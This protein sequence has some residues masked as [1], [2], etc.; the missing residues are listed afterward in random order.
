MN[1]LWPTVDVGQLFDNLIHTASHVYPPLFR[2]C[3]L[4]VLLWA[5][6]ALW[7]FP[8][9]QINEN[10][11]T[12]WSWQSQNLVQQNR[13]LNLFDLLPCLR[14]GQ[15]NGKA[16]DVPKYLPYWQ[17]VAQS[18]SAPC[19]FLLNQDGF[20]F[21]L[22]STWGFSCLLTEA[23]LSHFVSGVQKG[24][25]FPPSQQHPEQIVPVIPHY[26]PAGS[27]C[28]F[29]ITAATDT[30]HFLPVKPG[31]SW[32]EQVS[33][34]GHNDWFLQFFLD[35]QAA[36]A[37]F[38][39]FCRDKSQGSILTSLPYLFPSELLIHQPVPDLPHRAGSP[40]NSTFCPEERLKLN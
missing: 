17:R 31:N 24:E 1:H 13:S 28:S 25:F 19:F 27:P 14:Q 30:P 8:P 16:G 22:W 33:L 32:M 20:S 3:L 35:P 21:E 23:V 12:P 36:S 2:A 6:G 37:P 9:Q 26:A 5:S 40:Q 11:V 18:R 34:L 7:F 38:S 4:A 15:L 10:S 39:L 29:F